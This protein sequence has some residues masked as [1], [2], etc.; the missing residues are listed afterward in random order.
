VTNTGNS[1][2]D[3]DLGVFAGSAVTGFP[4]GIVNAPYSI[5]S[6]DESTAAAQIANSAA[7]DFLDTQ[8]CTV[9]YPGI[10]KDLVGLT[11]TPGV[12]C[13]AAFE[14]S[15][16]L[17]LDGLPEDVWIFKSA[18]T[19]ITSGTANVVGDNPCNVWWR[20]VSSATLGTGTSLIGN[21]LAQTSISLA[22]NANL[23]GR[24]FAYTGSVTLDDNNI[25]ALVCLTAAAAT[26]TPTPVTAEQ[27]TATAAAAAIPALPETGSGAPILNE[28]FPWSLLIVVGICAI[29]LVLGFLAFRRTSRRSK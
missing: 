18:A 5:H 23:L 10:S 4:P 11:L 7:F 16:T 6:A 25:G 1:V 21:I 2:I 20:V 14:L 29:A 19:L 15:G 24:A 22:T 9:N 17:T 12:Y 26:P 8:T 13:A 3:G 28:V 27:A